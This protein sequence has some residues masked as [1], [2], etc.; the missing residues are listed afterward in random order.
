MLSVPLLTCSAGKSMIFLKMRAWGAA[1]SWLEPEEGACSRTVPYSR[2]L[3]SD[4]SDCCTGA[5]RLRGTIHATFGH[6]RGCFAILLSA[7]VKQAET[8]FALFWNSLEG[9]FCVIAE[10]R[11]KAWVQWRFRR[12]QRFKKRFKRRLFFCLTIQI[13]CW[14]WCWCICRVRYCLCRVRY[15]LCRV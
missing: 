10:L 4:C 12:S 8:G 14:C 2:R 1:D 9:V 5:P 13:G 3:N 7:V 15:C 11:P 6:T